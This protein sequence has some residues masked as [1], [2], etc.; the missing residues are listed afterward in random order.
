M[1]QLER[2]ASDV[3]REAN[4]RPPFDPY[5]LIYAAE[6]E[7][8]AL[9]G[10]RPSLEGRTIW[11]RAED[12]PERQR[13]TAV[14]ELAHVLLRDRGIDGCEWNTNWL[15]SALIH[16]RGWF[17]DCLDHRRWDL[18]ALRRDCKWSSYEAIGR[19]VVNLKPAVLW[20]CDR[21][22]EGRSSR[23]TRSAGVSA[24][25][26]EPTTL[27]RSL[28]ARAATR[29]RPQR[30]GGVGAWPVPR[31][32]GKHLRVLSLAPADALRT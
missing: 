15:A 21:G 32:D 28:V 14:H 24:E 11:V 19:R 20:V 25:L 30:S 3:L 22:P 13:F 23:R 27:E 18:A 16:E 17:L 4:L 5:R 29:M 10:I 2:I 9:P 26:E 1:E 6:F 31:M 12:P 8:R 7:P